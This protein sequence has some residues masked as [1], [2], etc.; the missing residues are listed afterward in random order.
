[1]FLQRKLVSLQEATAAI[2]TTVMSLQGEC[3]KTSEQTAILA[4]SLKKLS[5]KVCRCNFIG[6]HFSAIV[7]NLNIIIDIGKRDTC[8]GRR[9]NR[10]T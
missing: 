2:N 1:M 3:V 10:Q 6:R 4:A 9:I 5:E 8:N 7:T